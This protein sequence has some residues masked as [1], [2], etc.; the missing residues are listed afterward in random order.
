MII[1]SVFFVGAIPF[2]SDIAN[3]FK[4]GVEWP[5]C[6]VIISVFIQSTLGAIEFHCLKA[7]H[8]QRLADQC[9]H[10]ISSKN[11][12]WHSYWERMLKYRSNPWIKEKMNQ[13]FPLF[14][15]TY[16]E[17]GP[18]NIHDCRTSCAGLIISWLNS[19]WIPWHRVIC[20]PLLQ[21]TRYFNRLLTRL[22]VLTEL[23]SLLI[24]YEKTFYC[25]AWSLTQL[26]LS[27]LRIFFPKMRFYHARNNINHLITGFRTTAIIDKIVNIFFCENIF[28]PLL[29]MIYFT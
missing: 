14:L 22:R 3:G 11:L 16:S 27:H 29:V 18:W 2:N 8:L 15:S 20:F 25:T 7:R 19:K 21:R 13:C 28:V 9:N 10:N 5:T 24:G 23:R 17:R 4:H 6:D 26:R 1:W 12:F